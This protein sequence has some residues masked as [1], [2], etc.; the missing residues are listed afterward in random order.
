[1]AYRGLQKAGLFPKEINNII[2]N[3]L[4]DSDKTTL[5]KHKDLE[6]RLFLKIVL[7]R[8]FGWPVFELMLKKKGK[9][10]MINNLTEYYFLDNPTPFE[11]DLGFMGTSTT[12]YKYEDDYK[13][14]AY[15]GVGIT[16]E[17]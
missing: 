6:C 16:D 4:I 12:K 15:E 10:H 14:L 1:M 3:Y 7:E 2:L 8:L 17:E 13:Y 11:S 5:Y 9:I